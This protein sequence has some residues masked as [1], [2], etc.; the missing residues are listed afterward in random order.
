MQQIFV[1]VL[2]GAAVILFG[3]RLLSDIAIT[4]RPVGKGLLDLGET[5]METFTNSAS[6][7]GTWVSGWLGP[8]AEEGKTP[9]KT[10]TQA[11]NT[12]KEEESFLQEAEEF[13]KDIVVGLAEEEAASFIKNGLI[14]HHLGSTY[15]GNPMTEKKKKT[16]AKTKISPPTH[17]KNRFQIAEGYCKSGLLLMKYASRAQDASVL[18]SL[19]ALK[20]LAVEAY[21]K[22][23]YELDHKKS[24]TG[25]D[26]Q[27][28]FEALGKDTQEKIGTYFEEL[29]ENSEFIKMAHAQHKEMKGH[30][31]K[32]DLDHVLGE[33]S[34]AFGKRRFFF[35]PEHKVSFLAF[36]EIRDALRR[37]LLEL[38]PELGE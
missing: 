22:C 26:L 23:L 13:G 37:R 2:V 29:I 30:H 5:A 19:M 33:W 12:E 15:V 6:Q 10:P 34:H 20:G 27:K 31:M 14:S 28:L 4:L 24:Y 3:P 1:G 35:D 9:T 32:M 18:H 16:S 25:D 11:L 8:S 21:L 36:R 7:A 17:L 38:H